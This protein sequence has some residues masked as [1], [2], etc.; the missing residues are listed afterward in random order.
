MTDDIE[1][2]TKHPVYINE[3]PCPQKKKLLGKIIAKKK[4]LG[5]RF[6]WSRN[7]KVFKRKIENSK[8]VRIACKADLTKMRR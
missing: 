8:I 6:A 2:T 5:W 7:G 4:E 3:H 1:Y